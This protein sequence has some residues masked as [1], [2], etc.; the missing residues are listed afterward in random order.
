LLLEKQKEHIKA[1][2]KK[3]RN[4]I[5]HNEIIYAATSRI[6]SIAFYGYIM[7]VKFTSIISIELPKNYNEIQK[8]PVIFCFWHGR[9]MAPIIARKCTSKV[10]V[11]LSQGKDAEL[12]VLLMRMFKVGT[13]RGSAARNR[14]DKGGASSFKQMVR[15]LK[16]QKENIAI[17]PDG[18]IGPRMRVASGVAMLSLI[19]GAKVVALTVS[20]RPKIIFNTWD[21]FL[22]LLPFSKIRVKFENPVAPYDC[23]NNRKEL[24]TYRSEIENVMISLTHEIDKKMKTK[25]ISPEDVD[26]KNNPFKRKIN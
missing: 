11:L 4:F 19:T 22:F 10:S 5:F 9:L 17:A 16:E 25:L 12:V 21:K 8:E 2:F 24:E 20:A 6:I 23:N 13:I 1:F 15:M 18:P 3:V 26:K 14:Q 7:F